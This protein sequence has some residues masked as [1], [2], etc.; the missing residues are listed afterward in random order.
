MT[1]PMNTLIDLV[2][3]RLTQFAD[4]QGLLFREE[5]AWTSMTWGEFHIQARSLAAA[6][7]DGGLKK[8]ERVS[9]LAGTRWEWALIDTA[10]LLAGGATTTIYPSSTPEQCAYIL[11]NSDSVIVFAEDAEQA[12]KIE[13][14]RDELTSLRQVITL[15]ALPGLLDSGEAWDAQ[16][17]GALDARGAEITADDLAVLIY[18][19]GTT[20]TPKGVMLTHGGW[21][22]TADAMA[23]MDLI[24]PDDRQY[25]FLPL[26]HVFG[27]A[28]ILNS[29]NTGGSIAIDGS[30]PDIIDNLPLVRPTWMPAVPRIFEKVYNKVIGQASQSP[31]R[32]R[33]FKW[34]LS[35]GKEA[36]PW[37]L[38]QYHQHGIEDAIPPGF[39]GIKYR[40]AD[41]LVF[42]KI[43]AKFGGRM[44]AFVSGGAP[45]SPE[46]ADFFLSAGMLILEGYGM[47]ETSAASTINT[48]GAFRFGT[49][50]KPL[51]G[52]SVRIE[53]DGEILLGGP[54]IMA[55]YYR[56][57]QKTADAVVDDE[58]VRWMH[59]GDLGEF[60][61]D[62]FLKITGRKKDLIITAGGKNIAPSG[63]ENALKASCP[64]ISQVVMHGDRR[65]F[66]VALI[67]INE[68][69][70]G[71]WATSQGI[72]ND[73]YGALSARPEVKALIQEHVDR[74]NG[75]LARYETLKYIALLDH[76]LSLESGELTAKMSVKRS[77]VEENNRALLDGFYE[78]SV[79][80]L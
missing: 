45:L 50:G 31:V 75:T 74:L 23:G 25:L 62:G 11:G 21:V 78:G 42:S 9:I 37:V 49:V 65:N 44:R 39:L 33:I 13:Q 58:G 19:S 6:L 70:V 20:G 51:K 1:A 3:Q 80:A 77:V 18:T 79:T 24:G 72:P 56:L 60:D 34:A 59:T 29:M 43:S 38:E 17:E 46:I 73:G 67:C 71:P 14:V 76:D 26:S 15:D 16:N 48:P 36:S 40:L 27:K 35:V 8:G 68:E 7:V 69:E 12:A 5:G 32:Y 22:F 64:Y 4:R 54:G 41:R 10:I 52:V 47:T 55:G 28:M 53:D 30:I 57:P 66:C 2:D 63:I 61:A